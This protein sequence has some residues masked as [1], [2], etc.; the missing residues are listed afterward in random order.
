MKITGES[1]W[2][3]LDGVSESGDA[4]DGAQIVS[5]MKRDMSFIDW[6]LFGSKIR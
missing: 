1:L 5:I 3:D 2:R 6:K 4:G